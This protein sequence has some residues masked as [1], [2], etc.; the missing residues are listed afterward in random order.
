M[1]LSTRANKRLSRLVDDV[2]DNYRG[3]E[4]DIVYDAL[5]QDDTLVELVGA[6]TAA[7]RAGDSL[8]NGDDWERDLERTHSLTAEDHLGRAAHSYALERAEREVAAAREHEAIQ[9]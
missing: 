6:E 8:R 2:A 1:R 7:A 5:I 9:L 3:R 4:A